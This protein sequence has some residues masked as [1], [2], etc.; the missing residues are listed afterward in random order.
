VPAII[1]RVKMGYVCAMNAS[2]GALL[3]KTPVGAHNGHDDDS[4]LLLE[5]K[6][7]IMLTYTFEPGALGGVLTNLA[8]ADGSVC[9]ATTVCRSSRRPWTR[10]TAARRA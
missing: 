10:S 9:V 4:L 1:G 8:V 7:T 5:H 3:W 2:T 6:L